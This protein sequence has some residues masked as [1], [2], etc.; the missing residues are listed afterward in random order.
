MLMNVTISDGETCTIVPKPGGGGI[1]TISL[2]VVKRAYFDYV[3]W[4]VD[5][6]RA[7]RA[8]KPMEAAQ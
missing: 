3:N 1:I 4:E 2:D 5:A 8:T 6:R 7:A